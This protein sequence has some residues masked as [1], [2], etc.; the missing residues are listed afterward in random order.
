MREFDWL[1]IVRTFIHSWLFGWYR[2]DVYTARQS[3][4]RIVGT[5]SYDDMLR[6]HRRP[7]SCYTPFDAAPSSFLPPGRARASDRRRADDLLRPASL[8]L[9]RQH[10]PTAVIQRRHII[11]TPVISLKSVEH[12]Y[13]SVNR[14]YISREYSHISLR[15]V[16]GLQAKYLIVFH[17][18]AMDV[19][20]RKGL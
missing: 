19:L 17:I 1:E 2:T 20:N 11:Q 3:R 14:S 18:R 12:S 16:D 13:I 8:L 7:R 10:L 6:S 9:P 15:A 4:H 5:L